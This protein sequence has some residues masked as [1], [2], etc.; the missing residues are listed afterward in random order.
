MKRIFYGAIAIFILYFLLGGCDRR[1]EDEKIAHRLMV[2]VL[3][4]L[5]DKYHLEYIGSS[6]AGTEIGYTKIGMSFRIFRVLNKEEGRKMLVDATEMLL[7]EINS[8]PK[9][10][11]FL[12]NHPFTPNNVEMTIYVFQPDGNPVY[13]PDILI[14]S[15]RKGKVTYDTKNPEKKYDYN[16]EEESYQDALNIVNSD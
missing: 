12:L 5:Y 13:K 3:K 7:N 10:Q 16:V 8:D 15:A 4:K 9:L 6:E 14:F 2:R 11:P 1:S